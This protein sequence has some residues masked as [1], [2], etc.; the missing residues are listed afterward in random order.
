MW[1]GGT[2]E[3]NLQAESPLSTEPYTGLSPMTHEIMTFAETKSQMLNQLNHPD[4]PTKT[5]LNLGDDKVVKYI[6]NK[7]V[8]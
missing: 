4:A 7:F 3:E 5:Y 2:E 6:Y 1:G 8:S